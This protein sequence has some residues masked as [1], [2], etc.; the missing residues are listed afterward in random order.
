MNKS[1]LTMLVTATLFVAPL[2]AEDSYDYISTPEPSQVDDLLDDD[3]DGVINARDLC[4]QTP[5]KADIDNE[6][7]GTYIKTEEELSLHILFANDSDEIQPVFLTQ[8][9]E[10]AEFLKTY[11]SASIELQGFASKVGNEDYNLALSERRA[12]SVKDALLSY[13]TESERVQVVGFGDNNLSELGDDQVS[14]AKNRKVVAT[15]V[16]H[17]GNVKEEWTIFT[18]IGK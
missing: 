11:P 17:K 16:G 1:L 7:C 18:K 5:Q 9:R 10:M 4:P 12:N 2:N 15:V 8:I 3:N 6:G 13:G 14:H